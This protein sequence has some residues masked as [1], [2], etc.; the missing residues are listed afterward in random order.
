MKFTFHKTAAAAAIA[1]SLALTACVDS[2]SFPTTPPVVVPDAGT[3]VLTGTAT[4]GDLIGADIYACLASATACLNADAT[5]IV[6]LAIASD[7]STAE[8]YS[9]DLPATAFG[10]AVV[11]R[12]FANATTTQEC[13]YTDCVSDE[14]LTGLTLSTVTFVDTPADGETAT[15]DASMS[16]LSTL[17]TDTLLDS[18]ADGAF[19]TIDAAGLAAV[20]KIASKS[21][22]TLLGLDVKVSETEDVDLFKIKLP[23]AT[24]TK[25]AAAGAQGSVSAEIVQKLALVNAS[26]GTLVEKSG[27]TTTKT[28]ADAIKTV[29]TQVKAAVNAT[30]AEITSGSIDLSE[31]TK[32]VA[33][34]KTETVKKVAEVSSSVTITPPAVV[35]ADKVADTVKEALIEQGVIDD[36]VVIVVTGT[37]GSTNTGAAN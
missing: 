31:V 22:A 16:V 8:G 23:S 20:T 30:A 24:G 14:D 25:L 27:T 4:K 26:F 15:V 34:I 19:D 10:K 35:E 7:V 17:A 12:V 33:K 18:A 28:L 5:S 1:A 3:V 21:V 9:I 32:A 6:G 2:T 37:T 13:D 29:S 36:T 11:I